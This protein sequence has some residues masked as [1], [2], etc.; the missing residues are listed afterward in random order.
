M[1]TRTIKG[2]EITIKNGSEGPQ[3]DPY[4]YTETTVTRLKDGNWAIIHLGLAEWLNL[5]VGDPSD[6]RNIQQ[7]IK[8]DDPNRLIQMFKDHVGIDPQEA[9]ELM[10]IPTPITWRQYWEAI[11]YIRQRGPRAWKTFW[12]IVNFPKHPDSEETRWDDFKVAYKYA[13]CE[14]IDHDFKNESWA[15][16]DS[17]GDA[18]TCRR[19]GY[20]FSHIYY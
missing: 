19:C 18:G 12:E 15:D 7:G 5:G 13:K 4:A 14:F 11:R 6:I 10:Y 20:S 17:G 3:H 16:G 1:S 9:E 2:Y 8:N